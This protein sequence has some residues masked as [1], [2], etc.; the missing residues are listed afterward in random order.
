MSDEPR[1]CWT[2]VPTQWRHVNVGDVLAGGKA[3]LLVV[4]QPKLSAKT[5]Q[6]TVQITAPAIGGTRTYQRDPDETVNV[7]V[8][9]PALPTVLGLLVD[10]FG[11]QLTESSAA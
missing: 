11:A 3:L 10:E 8:L 1:D 7:L 4:E 5:G 9:T 2:P 6:Y